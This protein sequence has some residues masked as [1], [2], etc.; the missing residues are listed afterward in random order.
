VLLYGD[1]KCASQLDTGFGI[2]LNEPTCHDTPAPLPLAAVRAIFTQ[3]EPGT[4]TPTTDLSS[5]QGLVERGET[6]VFCCQKTV[7][8]KDW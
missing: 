2:G 6:R 3:N 5:V 4:C 7:T 8:V 1:P